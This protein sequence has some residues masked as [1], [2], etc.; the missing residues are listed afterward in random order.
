M[1][2]AR[3][4][5]ARISPSACD[6]E[7]E[8]VRPE[9]REVAARA[10]PGVRSQTPA[11]FFVPAS[12]RTS[13][14]PSV[15][16]RAGTSASSA[17]SRP[18]PG[19]GAAP[20][21]SGARGSTSS[22][23]SVGKRRRLPRR[24]APGKPLA[25]ERASGGSRR[26]QR[27]DVRRPGAA[28]SATIGRAGRARAPRPRSRVAQAS[29]CAAAGHGEAHVSRASGSGSLGIAPI[30][31]IGESA[32]GRKQKHA[33]I[34]PTQSVGRRPSCEASDA[35]RERAERDRAEDDEPRGSRSSVR[36]AAPASR[37]HEAQTP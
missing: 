25:L 32:I 4:R 5:G 6:V 19:S 1:E 22:P 28:R 36:A 21:S 35:A 30:R 13:S 20:R 15:E 24:R 10:A 16:A 26:L 8:G 27:R 17:P 2:P 29:R 12:V 14:P 3:A 34:A 37:L 33:P 23:S 11:R 31:R 9:V 18:G 7:L